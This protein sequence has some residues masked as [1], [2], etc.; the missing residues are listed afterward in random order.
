[1]SFSVEEIPLLPDGFFQRYV[2]HF[3]ARAK[4]APPVEQL[5]L[6]DNYHLQKNVPFGKNPLSLKNPGLF[7]ALEVSEEINLPFFNGFMEL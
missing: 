3:F 2:E 4:S 1:L 7:Q 6:Y 5:V